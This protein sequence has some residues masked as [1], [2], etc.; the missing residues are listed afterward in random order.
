MEDKHSKAK[1]PI[2]T[3]DDLTISYAHQPVLWKLSMAMPAG[4]LIGILGPNGAG[5]ST[6]LKAM[7][8][9]LPCDR[10]K[11]S[12][13]GKSIDSMRK[14]VAYVPQTTTIDWNFPIAVE[15]V[16]MQGRYPHM[17]FWKRPSKE[18]R[19]K[20]RQVLEQTGLTALASRQIAQLSGGERQRVFLARALAQ[21]ADLY[22]MDEL[23][24]AIDARSVRSIFALLQ[25]LRAAGKT[26][27]VVHHDLFSAY[28][29]FDWCALI[30]T[31]LITTG[32]TD[33]VLTPKWLKK[34][35]GCD[36]EVLEKLS[37]VLANK[38]MP[39]WID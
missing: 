29:Y 14:S 6:L 36:L 39:G 35:Y 25:T 37:Q 38:G 8:G 4:K 24:A 28:N 23:L 18:D 15:E 31:C 5:K 3:I 33:K 9:L 11:I 30:N 34:T 16:V 32:P 2:V 13:W 21:D 10:G 7:M 22:L 26:V 17:G 19:A 27:V 20:V 12:F 1:P